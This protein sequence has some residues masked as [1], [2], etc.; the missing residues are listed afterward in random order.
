MTANGSSSTHHPYTEGSDASEAR[1][2]RLAVIIP[3]Y[4]VMRHIA[5]V[6][7]SIPGHFDPIIAV[8]DASTDDTVAILEA[9]VDRR[10]V[11][12]RHQRNRGV[13]GATKSGYEEA[14]RHNADICI[15]MDGDGQMSADHL[16]WLVAPLLAGGADYAKG[17]RF[18]D[19][20]A[21]RAMP[22]VRLI[23]NALL[24][25]ACK[26]ASGYWNTLDVTN[27]FTAIRSDILRRIAFSNLSERYFFESSMLIELNILRARVVDVEMPARY[28]DERSSMKLSRVIASF[29]GLLLRGL[30][31]RVYWRYFIQDFGATSV[32]LVVGGLL[33][34]GGIAF[35]AYRWW[36][37]SATGVPATAGTV[38]LAAVPLLGGFQC[39]LAA[40]LLDVVSANTRKVR[41]GETGAMWVTPDGDFSMRSEKPWDSGFR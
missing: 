12:V 17:N 11:L 22:R 4:N 3:C 37:S 30:L 14:L 16:E 2:P 26:A 29:P 38:L 20:G 15:K 7:A 5:G 9:L 36:L 35:G 28:G 6:V 34:T 40:L 31:R 41:V 32:L 8:D 10:L 33:T 23:G 1:R 18:V 27:G 24:S 21:L 19:T 39:L 25:L 13:G